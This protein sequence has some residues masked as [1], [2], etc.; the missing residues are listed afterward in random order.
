M[1]NK[2]LFQTS[3]LVLICMLVAFLLMRQG[4]ITRP[5]FLRSVGWHGGNKR[6]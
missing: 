4:L 2:L 3:E 6:L 5:Q 1:E